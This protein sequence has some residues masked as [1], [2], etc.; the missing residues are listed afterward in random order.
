MLQDNLPIFGGIL[1]PSAGGIAGRGLMPCVAGGLR[2]I[3][4]VRHL[5]GSRSVGQ[6]LSSGCGCMGGTTGDMWGI[7]PPHSATSSPTGNILDINP[8][9]VWH[10]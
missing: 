7:Y 6:R 5:A 8:M 1:I 3:I 10:G 2:A 4:G 9:M